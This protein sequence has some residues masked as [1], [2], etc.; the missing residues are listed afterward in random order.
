MR[1]GGFRHGP[2]IDED[3]RIV[4]LISRGDFRGLEQVRLDS[5]TGLIERIC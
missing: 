4:S 5:G 3:R 2:V 1:D